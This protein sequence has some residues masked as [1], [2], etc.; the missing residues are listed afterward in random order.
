VC[1]Q[2][3][4]HVLLE[5]G[6]RRFLTTLGNEPLQFIN[7]GQKVLEANGTE[8]EHP[9]KNDIWKMVVKCTRLGGGDMITIDVPFNDETG[10]Y[11]WRKKPA[12]IGKCNL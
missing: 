5:D 12:T 2:V 11:E 9:L 7:K 4:F 6:G 1:T 10:D 8:F 3:K